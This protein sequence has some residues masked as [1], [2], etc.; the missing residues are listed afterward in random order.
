G[1]GFA[2]KNKA[3]VIVLQSSNEIDKYNSQEKEQTIL[4]F[5]ELQCFD[6][7]IG[8][9]IDF[10]LKKGF[11]VIGAGLD[12]N[13]RGEPFNEVM[14]SL[15]SLAVEVIKLKAICQVKMVMK[16]GAASVMLAQKV[17][18]ITLLESG[19]QSGLI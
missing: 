2:P 5:D 3:Q 17:K 15:L 9:K 12:K 10:L 4:F 11:L 18:K 7:G 14:K 6:E 19:D 13:F 1:G 16:L 8:E